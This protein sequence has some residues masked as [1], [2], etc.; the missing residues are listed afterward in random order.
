MTTEGMVVARRGAWIPHAVLIAGL[1]LVLFP[2]YVAL[3]ASTLT[4]RDIVGAPMPLIPGPHLFD[5]LYHALAAGTAKT[6]GQPVAGML[7]NSLVMALVDLSDT[8]AAGRGTYHPD[9]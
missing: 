3:V 8:D 5:N 2:V 7:L 1:A 6:S 9:L 4:A